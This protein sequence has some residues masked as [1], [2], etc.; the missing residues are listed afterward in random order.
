MNLFLRTHAEYR[1]TNA[2]K[3]QMIIGASG[4]SYVN[5]GNKSRSVTIY[6]KHSNSGGACPRGTLRWECRMRSPRN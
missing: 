2:N 3:V 4:V 1:P 5:K 6:D